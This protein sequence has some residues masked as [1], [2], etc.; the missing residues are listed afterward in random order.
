MA[1]LS[2]HFPQGSFD[3]MSKNES[4]EESSSAHL[5]ISTQELFQTETVL[6]AERTRVASNREK[7]AFHGRDSRETSVCIVPDAHCITDTRQINEYDNTNISSCIRT[8]EKSQTN[9]KEAAQ[10]QKKKACLRDNG[11]SNYRTRPKFQYLHARRSRPERHN[12]SSSAQYEVKPTSS[13]F[14][15]HLE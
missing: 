4:T 15:P 3:Q 14:L 11:N 1:S 5:E 8:T 12:M 13:S 2:Y 10:N 9:Y 7:L 6:T